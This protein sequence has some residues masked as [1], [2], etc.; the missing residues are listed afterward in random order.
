MV[1][2]LGFD[3]PACNSTA[4]ISEILISEP[5]LAVLKEGEEEGASGEIVV[6]V[7]EPLT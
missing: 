5:E 4:E 2:K 1:I 7:P 3:A 6:N